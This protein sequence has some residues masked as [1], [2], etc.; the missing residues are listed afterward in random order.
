MKKVKITVVEV[1][2]FN[3]VHEVKDLGCTANIAPKCG[4]FTVGQEFITD[5][6]HIPEDFCPY[7]FRDIAHHIIMLGEGGNYSWMNDTGKVIVCCTDGF[8]PVFFRLER[9]ED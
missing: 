1:S 6:Q 3:K 4:K 5:M 8:R 2:D 7:A 9:I